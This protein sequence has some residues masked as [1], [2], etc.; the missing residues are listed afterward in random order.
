MWL[1]HAHVHTLANANAASLLNQAPRRGCSLL[2]NPPPLDC[3]LC[4]AELPLP[5]LAPPP[6]QTELPPSDCPVLLCKSTDIAI[7]G[8]RLF[9]EGGLE[10]QL[11]VLAGGCS[12]CCTNPVT[13]GDRVVSF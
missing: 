3:P 7:T 13:W 5:D 12:A 9:G 8:C 6:S 10:S 4:T 2:A 1:F 11:Q